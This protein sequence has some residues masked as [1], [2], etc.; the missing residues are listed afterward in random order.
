MRL[1]PPTS[2]WRR[3]NLTASGIC[4]ARAAYLALARHAN[5]ILRGVLIR[6]S[7]RA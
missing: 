6:A 1:A 4:V 7:G 3:D 2:V 5:K